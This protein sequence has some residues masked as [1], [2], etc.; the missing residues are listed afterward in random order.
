MWHRALG[1]AIQ[2]AAE[3]ERAEIDD[4]GVDLPNLLGQKGCRIL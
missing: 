3:N 2:I 1:R 4:I